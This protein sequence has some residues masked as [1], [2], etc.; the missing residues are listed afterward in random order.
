M[1]EDCQDKYRNKGESLDRCRE[2]SGPDNY[3]TYETGSCPRKP[4]TKPDQVRTISPR[5]IKRSK[6]LAESFN[7]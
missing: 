7:P 6:A 5:T 2:E 3:C 4:K 1:T